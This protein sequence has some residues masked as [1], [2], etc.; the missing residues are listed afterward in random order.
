MK[1]VVNISD[2]RAFRP[3][4]DSEVT[5][6]AIGGYVVRRRVFP[7]GSSYL[8]VLDCAGATLFVSKD[9]Q[10]IVIPVLISAFECGRGRT[11]AMED[12]R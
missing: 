10:D 8:T 12:A 9:V 11:S 5:E 3:A 1:N 7:E 2:G 4:P 6:I